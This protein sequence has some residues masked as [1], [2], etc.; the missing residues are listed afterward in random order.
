MADWFE[1]KSKRRKNGTFKWRGPA[2]SW[3]DR[4]EPKKE[5]W[6]GGK[7]LG[8]FG[9]EMAPEAMEVDDITQR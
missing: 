7:D 3:K 4:L 5:V 2:G 6:P 9:V 8:V 1:V